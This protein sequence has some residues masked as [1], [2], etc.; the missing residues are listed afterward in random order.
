[1]TFT[2]CDG[3][4]SNMLC[5][6]GV[7]DDGVGIMWLHAYLLMLLSNDMKSVNAWKTCFKYFLLKCLPTKILS[8]WYMLSSFM[9]KMLT[10]EIWFDVM[11]YLL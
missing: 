2:T 11:P 9:W 7:I 10:W 8:T 3:M 5:S 1:M 4:L 6:L